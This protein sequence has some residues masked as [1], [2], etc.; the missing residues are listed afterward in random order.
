[1]IT[2]SDLMATLGTLAAV[3]KEADCT[4]QAVAQW[5]E[6]IPLR[7]AVCIARKGRWTLHELRPGEIERHLRAGHVRDEHGRDDRFH[8][9]FLPGGGP[10]HAVP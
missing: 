10:G 6:R 4:K 8:E 7:C 1:M 5:S 9:C 3:A 2:K